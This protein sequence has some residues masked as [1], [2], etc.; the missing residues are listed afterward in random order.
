MRLIQNGFANNFGLVGKSLRRYLTT[1]ALTATSLAALASPAFADNWTDH[2]AD[3]GSISIDTT[4]PNTTNITQHT[5]FTKVHGDGDINAGWTV[6]VAQPSNSSKYVLY[7]VE[8]DPTMIMGTLNANGQIYIFDKNGVIFGEGSQV[9]VGAIIASTRYLDDTAIQTGHGE[10]KPFADNVPEGSIVMK[11]EINVAEAG[12]AAFVAPNVSN[13]GVINAKMGKVVLAAGNKVTLDLYGDNLVEIAVD[14]NLENAL[15]ENS[16]SINANGGTVVIAASTAKSA[17]DNVIN[18]S[19]VVDV[20]SVT[21]KGGKIILSGGGQGVVSVSGKLDASGATGG[22]SVTVTGQNVDVAQTSETSVDAVTSGDGGSVLFYGRDYAIFNG[23]VSG[24][25]GSEEGDG[26]DVEISGGESVGYYGL[27]DLSAANGASGTLLIDPK[28]LTISNNFTSGVL[29]DIISG[30]NSVVNVNAQALANT[31]AYSNVN[32]W[33]TET[34][35]TAAG[36]DLSTWSAFF[37]LITGIT[38]HDLTL[39]APTINILGDI[40]L[41]TGALNI[42]DLAPGTSVLGFGILNVPASGIEVN[43]VN[44]NGEILT[45]NTVGGATTKAG[46]SQINSQANLVNVL[47]DNASV[48]Q[49]VYLANDAGGGVVT[50][51]PGYFNES[52]TIDKQVTLLGA[53]AGVNPNNADAFRQPGIMAPESVIAP[54][55]PGFHITADGVIVDGFFVMGADNGFHVDNANNVG[56]YNNIVYQS[57]M[58]GVWVDNS[59][60]ATVSGNRV[61]EATGHGIFMDYSNNGVV[62][63]NAAH[64]TGGH[65]IFS[66]HGTT[67]DISYNGVNNA[68]GDGIVLEWGSGKINNNIVDGTD[69]GIVSNRNTSIE[70]KDNVVGHTSLEGI[71]ATASNNINIDG[72]KVDFTGADGIHVNTTHNNVNINNNRIGQKAGSTIKGD[73]IYLANAQGGFIQGNKIS[74]TVATFPAGAD[75]DDASGIYVYHTKD[76]TI[77][78]ANPALG[79]DITNVD[80]DGIKI[81]GGAHNTKVQHNDIDD[82]TRIGIY[83]EGATKTTV[84]N[85]LVHDSNLDNWGN[86]T[87]LGGNNHT[88]NDNWVWNDNSSVGDHGI[89]LANVT[90]ANEIN[91]NNVHNVR[92]DGIHAENVTSGNLEIDNNNVWNVDN[93]IWVKNASN[94]V[95]TDNDVD[96]RVGPGKGSYGIYVEDSYNALIGGYND[97]NDV[98]DFETGI[99]VIDSASADVEHNNV[100]QFVDYGIWV[101]NS[102]YVDVKNNDVWNGDGT[103]IR[104]YSSDDAE[105]NDNDIWSVDGHGIE[106]VDSHNVDILGNEIDDVGQHGIYVD[107]SDFVNI[108]HNDID[109]AGWDGINLYQGN[110]GDIWNNKIKNVDG[111]GID[112]HDNDNVEI[113]DNEIRN[114][115]EHGIEVSD[116]YN[117]DIRYNDIDEVDA[118]GINVTESHYADIYGNHINIHVPGAN[119]QGDGIEVS[120]SDDVEIYNNTIDDI[121]NTGI[122]LY[123]TDRVKV[124]NNVITDAEYGIR[125]NDSGINDAEIDNNDVTNV[126]YGI[127]AKD[128]GKLIITDNDIDGRSGSGKGEIGIYVEDSYNALIGGYH[129][130][131]DVEDFEIGIRVIDSVGADVEHNDVTEFVDYGI[132]A[133]N[134]NHIDIK[135]NDV[136]DGSGTGIRVYNSD[137]AEINDNNIWDVGGHGIEL[138]NSHYVDIFGNEIN[139]V[140]QHG[141]YVDPSDFVD[142][143]HN[144]IHYAGWDG[145]NVEFGNFADI[146]DNHIGNSGGDG[147]DVHDNDNAEIWGNYIHDSGD[148]G[149]EVSDSYNVSIINNEIDDSNGDGIEV[150]DSNYAD[151]RWNDITDSGDDGIDVHSSDYVD[152]VGNDIDDTGDNGI[153]V[154]FSNYVDILWN[155]ITGAGLDG[156]NVLGGIF[157]DI[158]NNDIYGAN[159]GFF[160][161]GQKGANRDGIHVENNFGVDIIDNHITGGNGGFLS[162]GGAG[163]GRDGIHVVNSDWADIRGN[164]VTAG[165]PGFLSL[166]GAGAKDDGIDVRNSDHADIVDNLISGVL[167]DGIQ[168]RSS[169]FAD[170]IANRVRFTGDDGID[171]ENSAFADINHNS[172]RNVVNNGIEVENSFDA[173]IIGNRVR[174]TGDDGIFVWNSDRADIRD[175]RVRHTGDDGIDVRSSNHVDIV[176][177]NIRHTHGDGIQVRNS[178]FLEIDD[179]RVRHAGDD[180]IDVENT[181]WSKITNNNVRFSDSN[182]IEL[183]DSAFV[184]IDGNTSSDNGDAGIFVDPSSFITVSSNTV[185]DNKYGIHFDAVYWGH[186]LSNTI[187]NNNIGL[188]VSGPHNGYIEV[189]DNTFTDNTIGAKFKSGLIDLTGPGNRF[190]N[191]DIAMYFEAFGGNTLKL[192]LVDDDGIPGYQ[193]WP[194]TAVPT[195]FGGTIGEQYFEGQN[196]AF[197]YLDRNTFIDP[198]SGEAIWLDGQH[199]TYYFPAEAGAFTPFTDGLTLDRLA[200]LEDMFHH[201]PDASGR[202]I[203]FFGLLPDAFDLTIAQEDLFNRFDPFNGDVTGLNVRITGLPNIPG[204]PGAAPGAAFNNIQT[205]AGGPGSTDPNALNAIET[206][207]GGPGATNAQQAAGI[208]PAA[209]GGESANC[210]SD[211]AGIAGGGTAV[212]VVYGGSF[213]DNLSQAASCGTAF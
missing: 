195:N 188:Y 47:S 95:I 88:I 211:A 45:R 134:S 131:N 96:G 180:G 53:Q 40:T 184:T 58:N 102:N 153:E 57:T 171:V 142:I 185:E 38:T 76:V 5:D 4:V 32:L 42:Y 137:L 51:A 56:I 74:N 186:V 190:Y 192:K 210:W 81:A 99:R 196:T 182:G 94:L 164:E 79:N 41:G 191:G 122:E 169:L 205:F 17:V 118:D 112:V 22:G 86:I 64:T 62:T 170:I 83:S 92:N 128:V 150:T 114:T 54:N 181:F 129:D 60:F 65:G 149:I 139:H 176:G 158:K 113:W 82:T 52:I 201:R 209:G 159:G 110:Y 43:V 13:S 146:W 27:T 12:L 49:G 16:G 130:G 111:D 151:I 103:G 80:W 44:V 200:F 207:A 143:A 7:D 8:N 89:F 167:G 66:T 77:G 178:N 105:I 18:M 173:D 15:V 108:A 155:D 126:E 71:L 2:V 162:I 120:D 11:G 154:T 84:L 125:L 68:G 37:G 67:M 23:R 193:T 194:T 30:G 104:V 119:A 183:E 147:I 98:E 189:S 123:D 46:D 116:S 199:S 69:R 109:G 50:V 3:E 107:P 70:I 206:A 39:A 25:G 100:Q 197:V 156:I 177:N 97:G 59:D 135:N 160:S 21:T 20:S 72:N 9:N 85:N 213:S 157:A 198:I 73:G 212:N 165:S 138:V 101:S 179:N 6:N 28:I 19:G 48:Q 29:A 208:E 117:A 140:G 55:S 175:N 115:G 106:L 1:T 63:F 141:I 33:A 124:Y 132:W 172:V 87:I 14:G 148:N 93:G 10:F 26:G 174:N 168:V 34:L 90:G 31:L 145:I 91:G 36:I 144:L 75:Y 78:G 203:F 161:I 204:A 61:V 166:G 133:S 24:R 163:A 35:N 152:I 127:W 136:S 121:G 187:T 202:G